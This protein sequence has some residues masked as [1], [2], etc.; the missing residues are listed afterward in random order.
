MGQQYSD[1]FKEV[2]L[3]RLLHPDS[4]GLSSLSRET[5]IPISTIATWKSKLNKRILTH[6]GDR[7][8]KQWNYREK[9]Q[10][11]F[12]SEKLTEESLGKWLREKGL[13][14]GDLELW[15]NEILNNKQ[16][17]NNQ[18]EELRKANQL[19]KELKTDLRKKEKALAEASA[20]LI[21]KKA[22][23]IWGDHEED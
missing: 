14:S 12:D 13:Q 9:V 22:N 7:M 16:P 6:K 3:K 2:I 1:N 23:L 18:K 19:I 21:L 17:N 5:G 20:L 11:V 8:P 4:S 15:K 10:A